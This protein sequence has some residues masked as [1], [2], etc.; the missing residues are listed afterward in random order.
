MLASRGLTRSRAC[1]TSAL[2]K[3]IEIGNIRFRLA[4]Q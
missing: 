2:T 3:M 4:I 1:P